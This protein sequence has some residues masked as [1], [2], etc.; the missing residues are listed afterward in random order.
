[1][2]AEL[3]VVNIRDINIDATAEGIKE[4]EKLSF[5]LGVN[6]ANFNLKNYK[7]KAASTGDTGSGKRLEL[8]IENDGKNVLSGR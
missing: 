3:K 6:S 2:S 8:N 5:D 4:D 7:F 1:M